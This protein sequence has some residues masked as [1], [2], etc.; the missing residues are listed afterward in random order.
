MDYY[1]RGIIYRKLENDALAKKELEKSIS[2]DKKLAEP[3]L[4]LADLLTNSN[5]MEAMNQCNEVIKNNDRN[6]EA[7]LQRA[8]VYIKNLDYPNAIN[9]ISKTIMIDPTNPMFYFARAKCYQDFN[10]HVNAI[11]D[12]TKCI[13]LKAALKME[14][15]DAYYARAK[16]YE[17]IMNYEKAMED[18]NKITA[19]SEFD[20]KARKLLKE[21]QS[22]LYELNREKDP[23]VITINDPVIAPH[24]S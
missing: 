3:R 7:Y 5:P 24:V 17:E 6:T 1:W 15:P 19:L 4:E 14:D 10:Q 18:Y 9:D 11:N 16:S 13:T 23:P 8:K 20:M 2:K 12:F 21:A 22:R